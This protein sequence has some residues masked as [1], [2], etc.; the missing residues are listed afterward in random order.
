MTDSADRERYTKKR[1]K[2]T[3]RKN[4]RSY[5]R[6]GWNKEGIEFYETQLAS[7]RKFRRNKM[8]WSKLE[9]A[10][11]SYVEDSGFGSHWKEQ[12]HGEEECEETYY[13]NSVPPDRF[14]VPGDENFEYDCS[15][16]ECQN[17]GDVT[18]E[19]SDEDYGPENL[20][21]YGNKRIRM[22]DID[23]DI[24]RRMRRNKEIDS[25]EDEENESRDGEKMAIRSREPLGNHGRNNEKL[26]PKRTNSKKSRVPVTPNMV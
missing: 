23:N 4:K 15:E 14:S 21:N 2:F 9:V 24:R 22:K 10:W 11:D 18:N 3:D 20:A 19:A 17:E 16:S 12:V 5:L 8:L 7:W 13:A 25:S 26:T 6:A 1:A